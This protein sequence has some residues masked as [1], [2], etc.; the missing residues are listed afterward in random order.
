MPAT[1]S[2]P[3]RHAD[4]RV[5]RTRA[6]VIEAAAELLNAD[7]PSALTHASVAAAAQI[8]RT[9]VYNHWPT[10]QDLLRA[11]IDSIAT[12]VPAADALTG[13]LREDLSILC[14]PMIDNL[15]DD[16]RAPMV[17]SMIERAMHDDAVAEIR[18]EYHAAFD[19]VFRVVIEKGVANG[20]LR[21]DIDCRRST[22]CIFGSFLF[23][24]FMSGDGFIAADAAV[25]LDEFV[26]V[27]APR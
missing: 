15:T 10:R 18:D 20:E 6:A 8:S 7:G 3:Q 17:A 24:R 4:P 12:V 19:R 21:A 23:M 13:S 27:N 5:E 2:A 11:T 26:R 22:A 14:Q 9:T 25:V 1:T 16:Q